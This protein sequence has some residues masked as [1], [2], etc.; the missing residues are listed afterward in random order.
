MSN[1]RRQNR[2]FAFKIETTAG[3]DAAPTVGANAIA[4]EDPSFSQEWQLED[5]NE[6]TGSLDRSA[7]ITGGGSGAMTATALLKGAGAGGSAPEVGPLLRVS[8]LAETLLASDVTGVTQAGSTTTEVVLASGAISANDDHIGSLI[9]V[10]GAL[11]VITDSVASSDTVTVFPPL[12]GAPGTGVAY[13]VHA[14]ATYE[15]A[16]TSL[17]TG[18]GYLW[19]HNSTGGNARLHKVLGAVAT[20]SLTIPV[21]RPGRFSFNLRGQ[22]QAVTDVTDPGAATYDGET[23]PVFVGATA[24]LGSSAVKFSEFS[25]DFGNEVA[26]ADD[27]GQAYGFDVGAVVRRRITGRVNPR[28]ENVATRNTF[29]QIAA[30]TSSVFWAT[31]GS[32]DGRTV[33]IL[34]PQFRPINSS[35]ADNNGF[36]HEGID[37]AALGADTAVYMNIS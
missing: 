37:F 31:W 9:T 34:I 29:A 10:D 23:P 12:S 7:Q 6:V 16:S 17:E 13:T 3:T 28:S 36:G 8:A 1:F 19:E 20:C 21:R 5:T 22:L 24:Y 25:L 35:D 4:V 32:G 15:P 26:L 30:G 2:T 18:S 27:P 11:R 33:S 14:G